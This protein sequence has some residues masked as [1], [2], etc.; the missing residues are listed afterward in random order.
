M[1]ERRMFSSKIVCSD[2][3]TEMPFSAQALY[4]QL[5]MEADDD[6]FLNNARRVMRTIGATETD[7]NLL[8]E[9]RFILGFKNGVVVI[10]HW[11]MNNQIRK[12][13]YT[14][15]QYQDEFNLLEIKPD[16]AY[17]EKV[18]EEVVDTMA[19]T[20][21]PSGNHLAPQYSIGKDSI[22]KVSIEEEYPDSDESEIT[23]PPEKQKR[24]K[25]E[26]H[27]HGEFQNVLLTDDEFE[28]LC[29]D[30]GES[31]TAKA[32]D[33]LDAYIE[34][35]GYKSKSHNLAIRRW[36]MDAV[37]ERGKKNGTSS[38]DTDEFFEAALA[39]S[40]EESKSNP[41]KTAADDDAIRARMEALKER[42]G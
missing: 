13:R 40:W 42:L 32:V 1:A 30:F 9:K 3:F 22:G 27:K 26:K 7:L 28:K 8:F 6:G 16:G 17:T 29:A 35:K 2:A 19:T 36:V 20:W 41:P 39:R 25:P 34:E 37:K 21:Q 15:T 23:P 33:F 12:D 10:K 24:K 11:R 14:P 38:F 18:F 5:N 4:T 31:Q